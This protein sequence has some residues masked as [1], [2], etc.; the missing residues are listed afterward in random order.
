MFGFAKGDAASYLLLSNVSTVQFGLHF[1]QR[2]HWNLEGWVPDGRVDD[3]W[4]LKKSCFFLHDF[5]F[6]PSLFLIVPKLT[7]MLN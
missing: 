3:G 1:L 4:V 2:V 5:L 7:N 6:L